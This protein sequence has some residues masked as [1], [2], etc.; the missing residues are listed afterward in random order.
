M[1]EQHLY[2]HNYFQLVVFAIV[3]VDCLSRHDIYLCGSPW[4]YFGNRVWIVHDVMMLGT[5]EKGDMEIVVIGGI[6]DQKCGYM[7]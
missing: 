3:S 5:L 4:K 7:W 1:S 2:I 6:A